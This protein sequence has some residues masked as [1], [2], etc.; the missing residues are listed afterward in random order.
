MS[1][2]HIVLCCEAD[3]E[4]GM[5]HAIRCAGL[6]A[7]ILSAMPEEPELTVLGSSLVFNNCFPA[8]RFFPAPQW[9][10]MDWAQY[11]L[12]KVDLVMADIP[13]YRPRD[14]H[15]VRHPSASLVV[16][17]DHGGVVPADLVINGTVL[18]SY[19]EYHPPLPRRVCAG[20]EFALIRPEFASIH[21]Q[22]SNS[23]GVTVIAGGGQ[24]AREWLFGIMHLLN[25]LGPAAFADRHVTVVV[26]ATFDAMGPL[27]ILCQTCRVSLRTGLSSKELARLM[28]YSEVVLVTAGMVLYEA[29]A[30]GV[31]AVAYP[32][33]ADLMPEAAWF[34]SRGACIDLGAEGNT[35]NRALVAVRYLLANQEEARAMSSQQRKLLDGRGMERAVK[36]IINLLEFR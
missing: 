22:I 30:L 15:K 26:G 9:S 12:P 31:P 7:L 19:H 18:P 4:V 36:E 32:Q 13:F 10:C 34:A 8:A 20:A 14:W 28:V 24:Q 27:K 3:E 16:I 2:P 1:S 21:W 17:D 6:L 25:Q 23:Q 35:I 33:I 11:D 5:G 29:I